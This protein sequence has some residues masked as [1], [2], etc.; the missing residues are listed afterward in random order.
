MTTPDTAPE[1]VATAASNTYWPALDGLRAVAVVA[2]VLYHGGAT[3]QLS[4]L[5]PGG[6]IGVSVFFTLSGFL[7]T[8]LL[9]RNRAVPATAGL[10]QFWVRRLKRL[11]PASLV[12]V[13]ATV[14]LAPLLW[15]G[16]KPS[17][18]LAGTFGY[19]NW[20]VIVSGPDALLRTIVGPLGPYWSLAVEEQFYLGISIAVVIAWR[21][22]RP[23][24]AFATFV[25]IGW[26]GSAAVQLLANWPNYRLE[27]GTEQSAR[28]IRCQR[29]LQRQIRICNFFLQAFVV[30]LY[31]LLINLV[32]RYPLNEFG[33]FAQFGL[34]GQN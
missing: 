16:M 21:T 5:A 27:F 22:R 8:G 20:H 26:C 12:V 24:R 29:T 14:S 33:K 6:F 15:R 23:V 9:L 25:A 19:T 4:G 13:L 34:D 17:D 3:S 31:P 11:A 2:V 32:I 18:A 1:V 28:R 7:V 30:V 10:G